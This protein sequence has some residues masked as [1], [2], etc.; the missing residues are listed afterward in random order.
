[1]TVDRGIVAIVCG[2]GSVPFSE[3]WSSEN[4][5]VLK[6]SQPVFITTCVSLASSEPLV[7]VQVS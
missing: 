5:L 7:L 3:D 4:M 2:V 6:L 1:M